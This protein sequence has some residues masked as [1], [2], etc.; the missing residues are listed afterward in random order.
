VWNS[1]QQNKREIK[2]EMN[3]GFILRNRPITKILLT[4]INTGNKTVTLSGM[5]LILPRK[6][7]NL[8]AILRPDSL[9]TFPHDLDSGKNCSVYLDPKNLAEELREEEFSGVI[10]VK[11]YFRDG[12][13]NRYKSKTFKFEID[14][15]LK[16]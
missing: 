1:R 15:N 11:G 14:E 7:K 10:K 3:Y 13:G 8:F 4:A 12:I 2:V 16:A 6:E 9:V 5:G